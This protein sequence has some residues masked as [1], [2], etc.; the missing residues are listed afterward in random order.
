MTEV[1]TGVVGDALKSIVGRVERLN[2]EKK[3]LNAD[4]AD[5]Y[6]TAKSQRFD[7]SVIKEIIKRRA[8][9]PHE[10]DEFEQLIDLYCHSIGMINATCAGAREDLE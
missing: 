10:R 5:I 3:E 6:K 9:D 7:T 1:I 8:K 2:E 4:I